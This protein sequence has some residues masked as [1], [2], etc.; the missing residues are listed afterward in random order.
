MKVK[1]RIA[2]KSKRVGTTK[3]TDPFVVRENI[4]QK[5]KHSNKKISTIKHKAKGLGQA[6]FPKGAGTVKTHDTAIAFLLYIHI[7][8]AIH[9]FIFIRYGKIIIICTEK[10]SFSHFLPI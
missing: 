4:K 8:T 2:N 10:L 7:F 5:V 9:L 6:F 3:Y 1:I